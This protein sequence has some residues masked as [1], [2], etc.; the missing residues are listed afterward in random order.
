M[1]RGFLILLVLAMLAKSSFGQRALN[2]RVYKVADGLADSACVSLSLSPRGLVLVRHLSTSSYSVLDGYSVVVHPAPEPSGRLY[3][4]PGGQLWTTASGQLFEAEEGGWTAHGLPGIVSQAGTPRLGAPILCPVRQGLT[5]CLA[6]DRLLEFDSSRPAGTQARLLRAANQTRL[7]KFSSLLVS[8]DGGLWIAG[9]LGLAKLT[10]P[11]RNITAEADWQ[12]FVPPADLNIVNLQEPHEDLKGGITAVAESATNHHKMIVYFDLHSWTT[13]DAGN[14]K[15]RHAWRGPDHSWWA[16]SIG[17]LFHSGPDRLQ[18]TENEEISARQYFD[19]LVEP[20]GCFWLATSEGLFRYAPLLWRSP[21]DGPNT[22]SLVHCLAGDAQDRIWFVAAGALNTLEPGREE[23]QPFAAKAA[24]LEAARS[25]C[26][27]KDGRLLV[28]LDER[29][30]LFDPILSRFSAVS[31]SGNFVERRLVGLLRDGRVCIQTW[32]TNAAAPYQLEAFDGG[33]WQPFPGPGPEL[34]IGRSFSS[35]L[36]TQ[37]GDVW[38]GTDRGTAWFNEKK[39]KFFNA[40]DKNSPA[41]PISFV[42]FPEGK[43]WCATIDKVWQFDGR[44]W[45]EVRRGFDRINAMLRSHRDGSVWVASNGGLYR[46]TQGRFA[47]AAW[48]EVDLEEGLPS[49]SIRALYEDQR[50]RLWAGTTHGLSQYDPEADH[51]PPQTRV[52]HLQDN[53]KNIPEGAPISLTF[54]GEDK[55]KFTPRE[56][57]VYSY[58]LD[59]KDW[60]AFQEANPAI[61][62]DLS[63]GKHVFEVRAMDRNCN[64]DPK[65]EQLEFTVILPWYRETRL[66]LISLGAASVALFFGGVAVNRHRK[67]VRS[68]AAVE[69]KVAERTR[70]LEIA[71]RELLHSQKMNA[72]GTLA[73]GIAHDFNN[74]LSIVKGSAQIIEDNLDN[75]Q[76]IRTRVDRIK[77]V[78]EQGAGIVK[79]MLGFSRES[80]QQTDGCDLNRL[81]EDTIKLL[82]DRFLREV[83]VRFEAKPDLPPVACAKDFVQQILLNFIFN[84][85]EAM[86]GSKQIILQT[87]SIS[88]LPPGLVLTPLSTA[89]YLSVSVRD[90]GCGITPE[91]LPRIFEPFFTTKALSARR[92]TGLGLSMVYELARK[93][94][95]GV[96]VESTVGQGSLFT[97]VLPVRNHS[98]QP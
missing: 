37:N 3:E 16:A 15:I 75:P 81:V 54:T 57:L 5:L 48:V 7:G 41:A 79:A 50:G 58:R 18:L 29:L 1:T 74:I 35:I 47:I 64:I 2:W 46:F 59:T 39:W 78:A 13:F 96:A 80:E 26:S 32:G 95:A 10:G 67:L 24:E 72:L 85:A 14:H 68:Y 84:A 87:G 61:F 62:A 82:G 86:D 38:F 97:L 91:N 92:G 53:E 76:K 98:K 34:D 20:G 30:T 8:R 36:E 25:L 17:A 60:S 45:S 49:T 11:L 93:L 55:W 94:E 42:E 43:I 33:Q 44:D 4:S 83:Q 28:D 6:S 52:Q 77:T 70:E 31:N 23:R 19:V 63:G 56:R 22:A 89:K 21:H 66:V 71:S 51:D 40:E 12:E 27:L 69:Q 9:A 88:Q 73:A 65:A 90:F